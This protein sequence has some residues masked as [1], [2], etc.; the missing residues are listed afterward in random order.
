MATILRFAVIAPEKRKPAS[1][2]VFACV[3]L[4]GMGAVHAA[5]PSL[6]KAGESTYFSC[7]L[8]N[9]KVV[10]ICGS[11]QVSPD[12]KDGHRAAWLQ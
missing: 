4:F 7:K 2:H 12:D 10:T 6:C 1:R 11:G 8:K 9:S 5:T 3:L